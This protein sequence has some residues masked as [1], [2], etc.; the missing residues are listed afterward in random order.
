MEKETLVETSP[1]C[2]IDEKDENLSNEGV[3]STK[4]NKWY[5]LVSVTISIFTL[6]KT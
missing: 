1:V 3:A 2:G 6:A 5:R 4:G